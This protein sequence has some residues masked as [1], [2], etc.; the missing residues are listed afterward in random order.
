MLIGGR[1]SGIWT[2]FSRLPLSSFGLFLGS[3]SLCTW[4]VDYCC[5]L[6]NPA[7]RLVG[8]KMGGRRVGQPG[9]VVCWPGPCILAL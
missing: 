6:T 1:L 9:T 4:S 5:K 2:L 3:S 8:E 7:I